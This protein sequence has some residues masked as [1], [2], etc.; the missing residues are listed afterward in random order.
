MVCRN[1]QLQGSSKINFK[2]SLFIA[3]Q[4][5]QVFLETIFVTAGY[6]VYA[7]LVPCIMM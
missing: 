5:M 6:C 7:A 3:Q 2:Q 1:K 4:N